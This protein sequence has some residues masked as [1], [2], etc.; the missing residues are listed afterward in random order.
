MVYVAAI[1]NAEQNKHAG[2]DKDFNDAKA[3]Y[4]QALLD[5]RKKEEELYA[6]GKDKMAACVYG[7]D[8]KVDQIIADALNELHPVGEKFIPCIE[9]FEAAK[10]AYLKQKT[11]AGNANAEKCREAIKEAKKQPEIL[12]DMLQTGLMDRKN[13]WQVKTKIEE[14]DAIVKETE[15]LMDSLYGE[16]EKWAAV[17]VLKSSGEAS[18]SELRSQA[19]KIVDMKTEPLKVAYGHYQDAYNLTEDAVV[20]RDCQNKM[21]ALDDALQGY[22]DMVMDVVNNE[23]YKVDSNKKAEIEDVLRIYHDFSTKIESLAK[24]MELDSTEVNREPGKA[25][26]RLDGLMTLLHSHWERDCS[27]RLQLH[28]AL[29]QT[30]TN[31]NMP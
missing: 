11:E 3:Q 8:N 2:A 24:K 12:A 21:H 19:S 5:S 13:I 23:I 27:L 31:E 6:D 28:V 30:F 14:G 22:N 17:E 16:I 9:A 15:N 25:G 20:K 18:R 29:D 26:E 7:D 10:E 4:V 1:R